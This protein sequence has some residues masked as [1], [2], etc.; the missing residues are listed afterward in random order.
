MRIRCRVAVL[1]AA[2]CLPAAPLLAQ[3]RLTLADAVQR[4]ITQ[5]PSVRGADAATDAAAARVGEARSGL[6]PRADV[7][8]G[9]QRA[10]QP[11][12]AFSSLLMQRRFTAADF[13][14]DA[15]NHPDPVSN[16]RAALTIEQ[17]LYDSGRTATATRGAQA[18]LDV[19]RTDHDRVIADL[20]LA[21][22]RA[23]GRAV[24]A[25]SQRAAAEALQRAAA[26][27]LA[28]VQHRRDAGME[29]D[30]AALLVDVHAQEAEAAQ[31]RAT[32]EEDLARATL[33]SLIGVPLDTRFELDPLTGD[34]VA[35]PEP[36]A[37]EE[38][39]VR[40]RPELRRAVLAERAADIAL[41]GA[42]RSFLP[43]VVALGSIEGNGATFGARAASWAGGVQLRW[44]VF[45]GGAD[46]ARMRAAAASVREAS[47]RRS[48]AETA[49][50]LEA[51]TAVVLARTAIARERATRRSVDQA[52][53]SQRILRNRY[54]SGLA[55][56][57]DLLRAAE[58][59]ARIE[60]DRIGA[61][62]DVRLAIAELEH[63]LGK[64]IP[65]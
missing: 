23:Y 35:L 15:L 40:N 36:A 24:A 43:S 21:T 44:N 17:P 64:E 58:T 62:V 5:N 34:E 38:D 26:E 63:A 57:A 27:D 51:R 14:L 37:A 8:E 7:S 20:R 52:R 33:N 49:V 61:V 60:S 10:D 48:A 45:A 50:R 30:A 13:G 65:R 18:Q 19:T 41:A 16:H 9:W 54:D 6:L 59:L 46:A 11:V 25:M 29:T 28:R 53:E 55:T 47:S 3:G 1:C 32:G 39:A 56:S 2:V 42:R 4:A 22:V 31:V 12:F